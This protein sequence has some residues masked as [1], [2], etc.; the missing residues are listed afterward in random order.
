MALPAYY[1]CTGTDIRYSI[2]EGIWK[3]RL[4]VDLDQKNASS[5]KEKTC[6]SA[7]INSENNNHFF[8]IL[9]QIISQDLE[10]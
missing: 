9:I 7:R 6:D 8:K 1:R 5:L 3:I 10:V 4:A 2:Y